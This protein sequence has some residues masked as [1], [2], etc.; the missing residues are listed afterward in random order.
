MEKK[1]RSIQMTKEINASPEVIYS[2]LTEGKEL[3]RWFPHRAETE[4]VVGGHYMFAFDHSSGVKDEHT[5]TFLELVPNK[6]VRFTWP[7]MDTEVTFEIVKN[8]TG[9]ELT[10]NHT[11]FPETGNE[12]GYSSTQR[13][14]TFFLGNLK[15]LLEEGKDTRPAVY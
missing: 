7:K 4:P 12:E 2:M 3:S 9:S 13:G 15:S 10:I 5:G 6:R 11:G 14:W 8:A 1:T